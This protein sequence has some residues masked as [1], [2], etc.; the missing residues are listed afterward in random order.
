MRI[1]LLY[2]GSALLQGGVLQGREAEEDSWSMSEE[3]IAELRWRGHSVR[4]VPCPSEA[5]YTFPAAASSATSGGEPTPGSRAESAGGQCLR[6]RLEDEL[7]ESLGKLGGLDAVVDVW[8]ADTATTPRRLV[9]H[10]PEEWQ[11]LTEAPLH[12]LLDVLQAAR[13]SFSARGGTLIVVVPICGLVGMVGLTAWSAVGEAWRTL[14][15]SACRAFGP[16]G[17]RAHVVAVD[18][19][20]LAASF[21]A[22]RSGQPAAEGNLTRPWL[23]RAS[24]PDA[25][26]TPGRLAEV[27]EWL[28][29]PQAR[30]LTGCTIPL[31]GGR[32]MHP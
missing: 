1:A 10:S 25:A 21:D 2:R 14:V 27:V 16:T 3:L 8:L 32:W 24:L 22:S 9:E 26:P 12:H 20:L 23:T 15:K 18:A 11:R 31:D 5:E 13:T 4:P 30:S 7:G 6:K 19:A 17:F 29:L 28:M